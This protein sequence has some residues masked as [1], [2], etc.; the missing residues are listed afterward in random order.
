MIQVQL[1][2]CRFDE[3]AFGGQNKVKF[4][5]QEPTDYIQQAFL[6]EEHLNALARAIGQDRDDEG[7]ERF[8]TY[9]VVLKDIVLTDLEAMS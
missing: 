5:I 4:M 2:G 6:L 3:C 7:E 8:Q 1:L 9:S